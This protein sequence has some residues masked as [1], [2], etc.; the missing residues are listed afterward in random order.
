[1]K[2][3]LLLVTL[4]TISWSEIITVE[5]ENSISRALIKARPGDTLLISDGTYKENIIL[6]RGVTLKAQNRHK[7]ILKGDGRNEVIKMN[8]DSQIDGLVITDGGTGVLNKITRSSIINCI[9]INNRQSGI[10]AIKSLPEIKNCAIAFNG[11]SGIQGSEISQT[12]GVLEFLSIV[13]NGHSGINISTSGS[14]PIEV[15]SSILYRNIS[16]PINL[17][18]NFSVSNNIITPAGRHY[19]ERN[20]NVKPD[21]K[22]LNSRS[23]DFTLEESSEGKRQA[24]GGKDIGVNW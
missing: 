20:R 7:A 12:Q 8:S 22:S 10:L 14:V 24:I 6:K 17:N 3:I 23:R 18:Q 5:S 19:I 1:M 4:F 13:R 11:T 2:I 9:I 16:F 21:F 15:S